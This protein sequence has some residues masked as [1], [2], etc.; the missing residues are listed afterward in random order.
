MKPPRSVASGVLIAVDWGTSK[1]R[2]LLLDSAGEVLAEAES[3][4]GIGRLASGAHE[5][6]FDRLV[7][8]WPKVPAIMAGMVGSRQGW[9]EAPYVPVPATA[10]ALAARVLRFETGDGRP[11]A[12]VPGVMVRDKRR[13]GDVIRGEETQIVGL[14]EHERR[15]STASPSCRAAI[16]NGRPSKTGR[17]CDFQTFLTGEMFDL[18]S[19]HS[20]LRHSV[21]EE[22]RDLSGI[23][24]FELAV[25]RTVEDDLPFLAAIFSV[26]VRQLLDGVSPAGQ[27]RLSLRPGDR[28]RDRRGAGRGPTEGRH[29][30]PHRRNQIAGAGLRSRFRDPRPARRGARRQGDGGRRT[31]PDRAVDGSSR[32]RAGDMTAAIFRGHRPLIAILRGITPGEA[33]PVLEALIA[34]GIGLIEVPLNSPAPL[35]SIKTMAA[36][37]GDRARIGA[38][39]VLS[40]AD[41]GQVA[42]CRRATHRVAQP[43]R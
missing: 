37:A 18:L 4:D 15:T 20:M 14:V 13:D 27:S 1:F 26:R 8:G 31:C 36:K 22:G 5:A 19:R 30:A 41:V 12:I 3:D 23:S 43:Q 16:R 11:V 35:A 34:A 39:T 9:R 10:A 32:A 24:D 40:V 28:R 6:A 29:G 21:A 17:S 42:G 7:A 33:E 25:R 38:G 2:A